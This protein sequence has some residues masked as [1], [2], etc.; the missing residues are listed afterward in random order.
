MPL[1]I[2]CCRGE[3][4]A[5]PLPRNN[6][7]INRQTHNTHICERFMKYAVEMGSRAMI[8]IPSFIKIGS[9]IDKLIRG[10][11]RHRQQDDIISILA[12]FKLSKVGYKTSECA[13]I[14]ISPT[15]MIPLLPNTI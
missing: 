13:E 3:V 1:T 11:H 5:E 8:C 4:F 15:T 6:R 14:T 7:G 2:V 9:S 10:I 12:F